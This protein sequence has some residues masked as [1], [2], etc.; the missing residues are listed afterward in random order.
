MMH[1]LVAIVTLGHAL[2]LLSFHLVAQSSVPPGSTHQS[3]CGLD[4]DLI[5]VPSMSRQG[6][7]CQS[8]LVCV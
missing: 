3:V 6:L 2:W 1:M 7:A 5:S 8:T 4:T